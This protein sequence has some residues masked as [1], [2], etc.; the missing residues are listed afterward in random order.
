MKIKVHDKIYSCVVQGIT[1]ACLTSVIGDEGGEG[2]NV[3][4]K[5][6]GVWGKGGGGEGTT[7]VKNSLD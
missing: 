1:L 7:T 4:K 6:P 3:T 2:G 5:K